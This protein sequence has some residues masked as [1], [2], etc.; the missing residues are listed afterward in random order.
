M[1]VLLLK[2]GMLSS[3]VFALGVGDFVQV[4]DVLVRLVE[5]TV[6]NVRYTVVT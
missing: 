4:G 6:T 2:I 3:F 1:F 5:P